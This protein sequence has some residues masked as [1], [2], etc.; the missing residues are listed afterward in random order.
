MPEISPPL[1]DFLKT[2]AL[3]DELGLK[4][5]INIASG[6]GFEYYTGLIFQLFIGEEKVGGGG[7]YDALIPS[8]GGGDVPASGFALY[9]DRLMEL[10]N[11]RHCCRRRRRGFWCGADRTSHEGGL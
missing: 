4:Y 10:S 9:L 11:R 6:A 1:D 3:L 8:M 7:R 2:V 5:Q